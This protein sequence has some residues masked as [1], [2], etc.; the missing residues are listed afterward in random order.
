MDWHIDGRDVFIQDWETRDEMSVAEAE[1]R[2]NKVTQTIH[3]SRGL[4]IFVNDKVKL[5][6]FNPNDNDR[7]AREMWHVHTEERLR[8]RISERLVTKGD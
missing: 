5:L 8:Q 3:L 4:S 6:C 7:A 2:L 1:R